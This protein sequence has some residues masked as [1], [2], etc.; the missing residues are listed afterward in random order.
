MQ[1]SNSSDGE[2][3]SS[4]DSVGVESDSGS[5]SS[6]SDYE[7]D[8]VD[9]VSE[10]SFS[11]D[12]EVLTA[13]GLH[14]VAGVAESKGGEDGDEKLQKFLS[15]VKAHYK[16]NR[17]I[18]DKEAK[19]DFYSRRLEESTRAVTPQTQTTSPDSEDSSEESVS[20]Y[21]S[22]ESEK[23]AEEETEASHTWPGG[24]ILASATS[25]ITTSSP[26]M[27]VL[28]AVATGAA[29]LLGSV[30]AVG[31]AHRLEIMSAAPPISEDVNNNDSDGTEEDYVNL[32]RRSNLGMVTIRIPLR[33]D[34]WTSIYLLSLIFTSFAPDIKCIPKYLNIMLKSTCPLM[35]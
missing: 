14:D 13:S 27:L 22:S 28:R 4:N 31:L 5:H 25:C 3:H 16:T 21:G 10:T 2:L 30:G 33:F 11:S 17:R 7:A 1:E 34:C 20:T 18:E 12:D 15:R 9:S 32:Q 24:S 8:H 6:S 23:D 19:R 26:S 29:G 35:D